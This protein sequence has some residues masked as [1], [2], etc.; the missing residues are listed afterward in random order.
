MMSKRL[1]RKSQTPK[2]VIGY[3]G[4]MNPQCPV[5]DVVNGVCFLS[6]LVR[7]YGDYP[8]HTCRGPR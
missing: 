1:G 4:E 7:T 5:G 2:T 8:D 3:K 6:L